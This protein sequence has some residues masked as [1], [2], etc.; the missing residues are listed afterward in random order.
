MYKKPDKL[1]K[2]IFAAGCFWGVE[3]T[4]RILDGVKQTAVGYTGGTTENPTYEDVCSGTTRHVEAVEIIYDAAV[5]SY[6]RLLEVFWN[7][8]NPTTFN[9]QGADSGEQYSSAIFYCTRQQKDFAEKS[10]NELQRSGKWGDRKIVTLILPAA[11]FYKAEEYHQ[12][13]LMKRGLG[14]CRS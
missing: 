1:E 6:E 13:Y 11:P 14:A 8:H 5:I 2:T 9:R 12:K 4:F 3:E 7:N 10:K